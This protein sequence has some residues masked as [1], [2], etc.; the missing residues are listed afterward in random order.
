M[1]SSVDSPEDP[2]VVSTGLV[3]ATSAIADALQ[4]AHEQFATVMDGELSRVYPSLARADPRAFGLAL[5]GS[6]ATVHEAGHS[7]VSFALMSVA[8]PF[9][10]AVACE[11]LGIDRVCGFVGI[12]ATGAPFNSAAAVERGP[13]GRTNPMVNSGA[14][15]TISLLPAGSL[16]QKWELIHAALSAFA[17]RTLELD[18]EILACARETNFRNRALALLLSDAGAIEGDPMEA[19]ELYTRQSCLSVT[20][21]D[22]ATMGATLAGGGENPITGRRVV[23]VESARAALVAMTVAGLY[24]HSGSWLMD[25]GL[26]GKSGI[27]GGM[28]TVS[29]GKGALGSYSPLLDGAG[30]SVRGRLAAHDVSRR[31]GLDI[32]ASAPGRVADLPRQRQ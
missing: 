5:V 8:K 23:G 15:A 7:R 9:T 24:E 19:I 14:I 26:P 12:D 32:F 21:L 29:P 4:S 3:P 28:V 20:A 22:L 27:G 31:L 17:G 30:N 16:E 13:G 2:R 11:R 1:N 6:G 10:F 25:V 18:E